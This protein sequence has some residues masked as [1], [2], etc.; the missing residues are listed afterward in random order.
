MKYR[1]KDKELQKKIDEISGG[2]FTRKLEGNSK[3]YAREFKNYGNDIAVRVEFGEKSLNAGRFHVFLSID[4]VEQIQEE[5]DPHAWNDYP[6]V[7]PPEDVLMAT[8]FY[9]SQKDFEEECPC[10]SCWMFK[11]GKWHWMD[12]RDCPV[13][14]GLKNIRF[15]PWSQ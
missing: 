12:G 7:K 2:D 3:T 6:E 5:Y 15:R 11:N 8:E 10:R 14:Y 4:D 13:D 9:W 1:L